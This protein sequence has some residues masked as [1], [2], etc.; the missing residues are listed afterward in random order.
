[1]KLYFTFF[2]YQGCHINPAVSVGMCVAGIM[3]PIKTALYIVFQ[4][5]GAIAGAALL[6]VKCYIIFLVQNISTY[7][8]HHKIEINL[9]TL[10]HLTGN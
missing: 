3:K 7:K 9:S 4:C 1:M 2:N 6:K 5:I 8:K 10:C